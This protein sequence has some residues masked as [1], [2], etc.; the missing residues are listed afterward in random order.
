[1]MAPTEGRKTPA[2]AQVR[3]S[4]DEWETVYEVMDSHGIA[5]ISDAIREALKLLKNELRQEAM[6]KEIEDYYQGKPAPSPEGD[7]PVTQAELDEADK[8]EF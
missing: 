8:A 3:L 2:V 5:S 1:M 4:S 7:P 6:A